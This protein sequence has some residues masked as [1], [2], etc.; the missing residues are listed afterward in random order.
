MKSVSGC[1]HIRL[2]TS[3]STKHLPVNAL[4]QHQEEFFHTGTEE[5]NRLSLKKVSQYLRH[6]RPI[7][8]WRRLSFWLEVTHHHFLK[9]GF[10]PHW[11]NLSWSES[12]CYRSSG[13]QCCPH[14]ILVDGIFSQLNYA[15]VHI[16]SRSQ[17]KREKKRD[18]KIL[19]KLNNTL[20]LCLVFE[21][22][23]YKRHLQSFNF[24][25][26]WSLLYIKSHL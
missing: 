8:A 13:K 6:V 14:A 7:Q 18:L 10:S 20:I 25:I 19:S 15:R 16:H 24:H 26:W 12:Q 23:K 17:K 9:K 5:S 21:D 4:K 1:W 11:L 3:Y 2:R 22:R